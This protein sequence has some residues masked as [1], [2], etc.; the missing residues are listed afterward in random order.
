MAPGEEIDK[1]SFAKQTTFR[2]GRPT[3]SALP[4]RLDANMA[5]DGWQIAMNLRPAP[6]AHSDLDDGLPVIDLT[7]L[8]SERCTVTV[9]EGCVNVLLF[10]T[11]IF[12][13]LPSGSVRLSSGG[14]LTQRTLAGIS[15]AS[16]ALAPS[17]QLTVGEHQREWWVQLAGPMP[18][19]QRFEDGIVLPSVVPKPKLTRIAVERALGRKGAQLVPPA[20]HPTATAEAPISKAELDLLMEL[21]QATA[22]RCGV[23]LRRCNGDVNAAADLLLSGA[24]LSDALG[25]GPSSVRVPTLSQPPLPPQGSQ[26]NALQQPV[27]PSPAAAA[28]AQGD[29]RCPNLACHNL[30]FAFRHECN[31]C[32][33]PRPP[34]APAAAAAA[35]SPA[36][37]PPSAPR[38]PVPVDQ[39]E[40]TSLCFEF[41]N[42]GQCSHGDSCR[43][44]HV[45]HQTPLCFPYLN[46]G[47]CAP[48]SYTHLTLPTILLV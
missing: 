34:A 16:R 15:A 45:E 8:N 9:K 6:K 22:P 31:R 46:R 32:G 27:V 12:T 47:K 40:G 1:A 5:A 26:A 36:Q 28:A 21:T 48:V 35:L 30:N 43:F 13:L 2:R 29:W 14:W 23:A 33:T 39:Q 20:S 41:L 24:D 3:R 18:G 4:W 25:P 10:E 11:I 42:K 7:E 44:R 17:L 38:P 37:P 19:V